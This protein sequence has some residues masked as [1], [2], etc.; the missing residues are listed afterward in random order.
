MELMGLGIPRPGRL[1]RREVQG[2]G[3][4]II[5]H[6]L[7]RRAKRFAGNASILPVERR[8]GLRVERRIGRPACGEIAHENG[9]DGLVFA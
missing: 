1:G 4:Q 2:A 9:A 6:A 5:N 7:E 3:N 8:V